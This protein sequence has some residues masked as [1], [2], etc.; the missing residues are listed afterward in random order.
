[1]LL[2]NAHHHLFS[3]VYE[4]T[5]FSTTSSTLDS[6]SEKHFVFGRWLLML[7]IPLLL[8]LLQLDRET[9]REEVSRKKMVP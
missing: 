2:N 8:F 5:S 6:I 3:L 9:K 4:Y 1:M 7:L